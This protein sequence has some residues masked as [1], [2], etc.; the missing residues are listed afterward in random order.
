MRCR[1]IAICTLCPKLLVVLLSALTLGLPPSA[2]IA[3]AF[4]TAA[5]GAIVVDHNTVGINHKTGSQR[6]RGAA[7]ARLLP[8]LIGPPVVEEV[9]EEVT[10]LIRHTRNLRELT[11]ALTLLIGR[12]PDLLGRGNVYNRSRQLLGQVCN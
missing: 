10:E 9:L 8:A 5:H 6:T 1:M 7:A 12:L 11:L 2:S 4:E 3:Q